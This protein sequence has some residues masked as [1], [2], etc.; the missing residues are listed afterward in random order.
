MTTDCVRAKKNS[1]DSND[2][3]F[4]TLSYLQFLQKQLNYTLPT[5]HYWDYVLDALSKKIESPC[6]LK[7][8]KEVLSLSS[9]PCHY[10]FNLKKMAFAKKVDV[11]TYYGY[12]QWINVLLNNNLNNKLCSNPYAICYL[13]ENFNYRLRNLN[14]NEKATF[15]ISYASKTLFLLLRKVL[16][17]PATLVTITTITNPTHLQSLQENMDTAIRLLQNCN[18]TEGWHKPPINPNGQHMML[19]CRTHVDSWLQQKGLVRW[20][21]DITEHLQY[22]LGTANRHAQRRISELTKTA[23]HCPNTQ[24]SVPKWLAWHSANSELVEVR[25][26]DLPMTK[27]QIDKIAS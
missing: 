26:N 16:S 5:N 4:S 14:E 25:L 15:Y 17:N 23:A 8:Y 21:Y 19:R 10:L 22:L 2:L 13:L 27:L 24:T 9:V 18:T 1:I 11:I 3:F 6:F 7:K 12:K 20:L